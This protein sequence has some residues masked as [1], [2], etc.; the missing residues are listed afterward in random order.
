MLLLQVPQWLAP[1]GSHVLLARAVSRSWSSAFPP[2]C[3]LCVCV[4]STFPWEL[5]LLTWWS[6]GGS[7]VSSGVRSPIRN[8]KPRELD[9]AARCNLDWHRLLIIFIY[10][11]CEYSRFAGELLMYLITGC[12][13]RPCLRYS[14]IYRSCPIYNPKVLNPETYV[15]PRI[16]DKGGWASHLKKFPWNS[17]ASA[18]SWELPPCP[19]EGPCFFSP[20]QV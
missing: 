1:A 12:C 19:D 4:S 15:A 8:S 16:W 20:Q 7:G 18:S 11:T 10:P 13:P 17:A 14:I 6:P 5:H 3:T 9:L 2:P